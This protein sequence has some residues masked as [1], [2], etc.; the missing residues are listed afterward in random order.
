MIRMEAAVAIRMKMLEQKREEATAVLLSM[1]M[2]KMRNGGGRQMVGASGRAGGAGEVC[3][4]MSRRWAPIQLKIVNGERGSL[5]TFFPPG[6]RS[7]QSDCC[8]ERSGWVIGCLSRLA[9]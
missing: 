2:M 8:W 6:R 9:L 7:P 5:S 3:S 4:E 1:M